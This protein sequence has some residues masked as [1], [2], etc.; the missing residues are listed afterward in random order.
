MTEHEGGEAT[1]PHAPA[2]ATPRHVPVMLDEVLA[3]LVPALQPTPEHP[4]PVVV[5]GTLGLGGHSAALLEACPQ[6]R[7]VGLDRDP[8][9]LALAGERLAPYGDRVTLVEAVY[10]ELP[11]VLERVGHPRVQAVLL[12]LGLSSLQI[13]SAERGF[14]Y[15]ADA[16]LDMRMGRTGP[17][18]AEVLNTYGA[19]ELARVLRRYG[20]ERFA[21]RIARRVVEAREVEPFERSGRLVELLRAAVPMASQKSGGHPA[22]RTFQALR[23][24]VNGELAALESVLPSAVSALALD[25]RIAV[26]AYHSLEDRLVKQVLAAGAAD[27]APRG[28]PVVP[29]EL[30]PELRLLT[31]GADRPGEAE[32]AA[33][34]RAASAR[35][36]G[37]VRVFDPRARPS[38]GR[39]P[40]PPA[41][42]PLAGAPETDPSGGRPPAPPAAVPLAGAPETDPRP[43]ETRR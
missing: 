2:P 20:E 25:G 30:K 8:Q 4:A 35:L 22:K 18:A 31:R 10:D 19:R 29:D 11:E 27:R 32:V 9:A 38:G 24:E 13:D 23:I 7:L 14:A 5:D 6:A 40:A 16:P 37:A 15:A 42:V 41:A 36:R 12:D 21:D 34:P 39:P 17:T 26:L 3:L 33:N 1:S 43:P 28:L